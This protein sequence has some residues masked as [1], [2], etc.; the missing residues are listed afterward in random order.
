[1][2]CLPLNLATGVSSGSQALLLLQGAQ[3]SGKK[4]ITLR[5]G[6]DQGTMP[7][8]I[9]EPGRNMHHFTSRFTAV[10]PLLL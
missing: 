2:Y 1:M 10:I 8:A 9:N 4:A 7:P 5:A 6:A 3:E